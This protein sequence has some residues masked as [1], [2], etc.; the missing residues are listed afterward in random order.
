ML[1]RTARCEWALYVI[2]S[3]FLMQ[4]IYVPYTSVADQIYKGVENVL[5]YIYLLSDELYQG[6]IMRKDIFVQ[7]VLHLSD[8]SRAVTVPGWSRRLLSGRTQCTFTSISLTSTL[9][10][11]QGFVGCGVSPQG[12]LN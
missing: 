3:H 1:K 6:V 11:C 4:Y 12:E 10:A 5:I 8:S 7:F 2:C 9:T